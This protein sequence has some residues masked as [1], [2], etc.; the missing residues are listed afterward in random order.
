M[1]IEIV[2]IPIKNSDF[3][4]FFVNV[5]QTV[6]IK[7]RDGGFTMNIWGDNHQG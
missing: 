5:Y 2:D 7:E 3:P 1:A 6:T 4:L